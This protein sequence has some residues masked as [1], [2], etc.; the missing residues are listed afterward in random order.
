MGDSFDAG[1]FG[2]LRMF[3]RTSLANTFTIR[4]QELAGGSSN[5]FY[6]RSLELQSNELAILATDDNN[7]YV[8]QWN[9]A[10]FS[11][12]GAVTGSVKGASMPADGTMFCTI[13]T[14]QAPDVQCRLRRSWDWNPQISPTSS[15]A[16]RS[17]DYTGIASTDIETDGFYSSQILEKY[18]TVRK[19]SAD[20]SILVVG[21]P[22]YSASR[23]RVMVY[24]CRSFNPANAADPM[25]SCRSSGVWSNLFSNPSLTKAL[26]SPTGQ[27]LGNF[28]WALDLTMIGPQ[29]ITFAV[30]SPMESSSLNSVG[31][32]Y[33]Y[34]LRSESFETD[35]IRIEAPVIAEYGLFGATLTF[36]MDGSIL[37]IGAPGECVSAPVWSVS[38]Q[39]EGAAY[40]YNLVTM[41]FEKKLTAPS[42]IKNQM[43]GMGLATNHDGTIISVGAPCSNSDIA[44]YCVAGPNQGKVYVYN[45]ISSYPHATARRRRYL[46]ITKNNGQHLHVAE[47]RVYS[48]GNNIALWKPTGLT[49][50]YG[51]DM[52]YYSLSA[53]DGSISTMCH[54]DGTGIETLTVDL[55]IVNGTITTVEVV[56]RQ[57]GFQDRLAGATIKLFNGF[58]QDG[59]PFYTSTLSGTQN[60]YT[61]NVNL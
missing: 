41:S 44:V 27:T 39:N 55:G 31:A 36:S 54:S 61:F 38:C 5:A 21:A 33:L 35:R 7:F 47:I 2:R 6:P 30:S 9:G 24:R 48:G 45:R 42:A 15:P 51:F 8:N 29:G 60:I 23:G 34:Y 32:V 46:Q 53:V 18:S 10:T 25:A 19:I 20:S 16:I 11:Y 22:R 3:S 49:S 4:A 58:Y 50:V 13:G 59:T 26:D 40:I 43:F 37:L 14:P 28:G 17:F 56:N 57:S 12:K 52:Q 1:N